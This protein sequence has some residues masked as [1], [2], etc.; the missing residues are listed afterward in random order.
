MYDKAYYKRHEKGSYQSALILLNYLKD[1]LKIN[2]IIDFGCGM[3]TWGKAA[4]D[5]GI[6]NYIG[7][8][9]HYY[10]DKYMVIEKNS[11]IQHDL[12][13]KFFVQRSFDLAI[14]V[15]VAEHIDSVYENT[16][17]ENICNSSDIILFS[18]ALP[19]QGGTGHINERPCS[20]WNSKFDALGY[21]LIDCIRPFFWNNKNI[22]I[23]Y[24]NN[25]TLY[26]KK[27]KFDTIKSYIPQS[28]FPI[29][30]I[31]PEMLTRI[32]KKRGL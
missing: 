32:L 17:I 8:D 6:T 12:R 30:I 3:G 11:Y 16:F 5:I 13:N 1:F 10:N 21:V 19:E 31:H 25:C 27:E 4:K 24:R 9:Q 29:D 26:I 14:S 7:V 15:E 20:Y 18:A 22:E 2:S 23:W 28:S